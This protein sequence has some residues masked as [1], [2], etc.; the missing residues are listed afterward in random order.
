MP[1]IEIAFIGHSGFMVETE[2]KFLLFD[3][4]L[5]E[6]GILKEGLPFSGNGAVFV[7]HAHSDHFNPRV[8]DL[9]TSGETMLV[10]DTGVKVAE[11]VPGVFKV[12][13]YDEVDLGWAK[14]IVFGSTDEGSSFL[15]EASGASIFHAGDLNDWYWQD[16]STPE[17]L[18][19]DEGRYLDE[20]GKIK[21]RH[22]DVAFVPVDAR[23]KDAAI[24][25]A[26]LFAREI[27]PEYIIPM[28]MNGSP[29]LQK[30]A[31][32]LAQVSQ[33]TKL[34]VPDRP[35]WRTSVRI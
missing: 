15:V 8:F 22:V 29:D 16:E 34:L 30:L 17:E 18:Q 3:L 19:A 28:H 1:E 9:A 12:S 35:G 4:Y 6:A 26:V 24:K 32:E 10:V 13:P 21:G 25:G 14:V 27:R 33:A 2:G 5:D 23:L 11:S 7:S 31:A 20:L